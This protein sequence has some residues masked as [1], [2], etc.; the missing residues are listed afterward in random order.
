MLAVDCKSRLFSD[1]NLF[2]LVKFSN[3]SIGLLSSA[4][5]REKQFTFRHSDRFSAAELL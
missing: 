4:N 2:F 3:R 5:S 1:L